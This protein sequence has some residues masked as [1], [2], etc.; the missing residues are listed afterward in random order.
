MGVPKIQWREIEDTGKNSDIQ[1]VWDDIRLNV[2]QFGEIWV[3]Y[4]RWPTPDG[5]FAVSGQEYQKEVGIRKIEYAF[6]R[7][8]KARQY[9]AAQKHEGSK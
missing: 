8:W 3:W 2:S 1:A 6:S 9:D 7:E 4:I 5:P